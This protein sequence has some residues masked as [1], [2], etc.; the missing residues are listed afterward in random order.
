[1]TGTN[2]HPRATQLGAVFI[3][4]RSRFVRSILDGT[5]TVELRRKAPKHAVG[6]PVL[7]YSSG[8]DKA[9]T[10]HAVVSGIASGTPDSIWE[11]FSPQLGVTRDEF[12]VYFAGTETAYALQLSDVTARRP[13]VA[14]NELRRDH[15]LEP[16]QSW[17]YLSHESYSRLTQLFQVT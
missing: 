11:R 12:N 13:P 1:M 5:K 10:V 9:V 7:V 4:I 3:S 14:L 8:E 15:G 16:P 2:D 17:R 6:M